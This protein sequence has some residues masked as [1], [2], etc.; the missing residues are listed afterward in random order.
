[1]LRLL[2]VLRETS[3]PH[4]HLSVVNDAHLGRLTNMEKLGT[5]D[6]RVKKRAGR[7]CAL[8]RSRK[9]RC[10]VVRNGPPCTNCHLDSLECIVPRSRRRKY[11][12]EAKTD[13]KKIA[14]A[15]CYSDEKSVKS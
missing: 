4:A 5:V 11:V 12:L 15:D 14:I 6:G 8:C 7:A 1:M 9:V 2:S 3:A 13:V 10:D